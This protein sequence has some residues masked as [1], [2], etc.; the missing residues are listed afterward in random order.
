MSEPRQVTGLLL[1]AVGLLW[2]VSHLTGAGAVVIVPGAGVAF[3]IAYLATHWYGLLVPGGILTGLGAGLV[4]ATRG[5]PG[6]AVVLG[7][8]L[9]FLA[10]TVID[11]LRTERRPAWWWPLIPGGV[12]TVVG[13]SQ[14]TIARDLG[15]YLAP[16]AL[17]VVGLVLLLRRRPDAGGSSTREA[18]PHEVEPDTGAGPPAGSTSAEAEPRAARPRAGET[19]PEESGTRG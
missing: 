3:V 4:V 14:I 17:L 19:P 10:I 9:G 6:E 2:L 7:L 5:G 8:G 11:V 1:I 12:L 15:A 18:T 13:A 16:A